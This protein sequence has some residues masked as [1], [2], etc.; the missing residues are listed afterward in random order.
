MT[1]VAASPALQAVWQRMA[2]LTTTAMATKATA[3]MRM[4]R[5]GRQIHLYYTHIH[6]GRWAWAIDTI[7]GRVGYIPRRVAGTLK[8]RHGLRCNSTADANYGLTNGVWHVSL[9]HRKLLASPSMNQGKRNNNMRSVTRFDVRRN[10]CNGAY[11]SGEGSIR[12][13]FE[14]LC[15]TVLFQNE[16]KCSGYKTRKDQICND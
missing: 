9:D 14:S 7:R 2:M 15:K 4:P 11:P 1:T 10:H 6:K 13:A 5:F 12:L 3:D 8:V 16:R